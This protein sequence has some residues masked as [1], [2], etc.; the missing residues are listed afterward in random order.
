M[1]MFIFLFF[2]AVILQQVVFRGCVLT[3]AE[4]KLTKLDDTIL[5][6]W[7][8]IVGYKPSRETRIVSSVCVVG[9]MAMTLLMNTILD[10][11]IS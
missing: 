10:Q 6:P 8:K 11:L 4:Q 1:R 2:V 7:I 5:D 9:S 3:K